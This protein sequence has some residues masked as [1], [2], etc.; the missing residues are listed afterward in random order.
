MRVEKDYLARFIALRDYLRLHEPPTTEI[1]PPPKGLADYL[2]AGFARFG[3]RVALVRLTAREYNRLRRYHAN[4]LEDVWMTSMREGLVGRLWGAFV[5][6]DQG[7]P[8]DSFSL[9]SEPEEGVSR[10]ATFALPRAVRD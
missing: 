1:E 6:Y 7:Q 9:V 8:L 2:A 10:V 3:G 5:T 4:L